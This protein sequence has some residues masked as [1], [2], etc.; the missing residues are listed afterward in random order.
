MDAIVGRDARKLCR[1]SV[2]GRGANADWHGADAKKRSTRAKSAYAVVFM[3]LL[4]G[5]CVGWAFNTWDLKPD[6]FS[7]G[8]LFKHWIGNMASHLH[9]IESGFENDEFVLRLFRP[10]HGSGALHSV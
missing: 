6:F 5:G 3:L 9:S 10:A 8:E 7:V 4:C 2:C 1:R